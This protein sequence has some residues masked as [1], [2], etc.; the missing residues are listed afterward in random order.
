MSGISCEDV[1]VTRLL[2]LVLLA[3]CAS[4]SSDGERAP[5]AEP[6]PQAAPAPAPAP[7]APVPAPP[8]DAG[9]AGGVRVPAGI[10]ADLR[11]A[12]ALAL[13]TVR[14]STPDC[15]S[16]GH[17]RIVFDVVELARGAGIQVVSHSH[18]L[19]QKDAPR[20]AAGDHAILGIEPD[21][22]PAEQEMCVPMPARQGR[23]TTAVRVDSTDAG[24]RLLGDLAR[25]AACAP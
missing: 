7:A 11:A 13:A 6:A 18:L 5:A 10:C 12:P 23:V 15:S 4:G 19:Y 16:V 1:A 14:A 8:P 22:L 24:R 17:Q 25:G 2:G 9:S 21:T 3:A 20:F